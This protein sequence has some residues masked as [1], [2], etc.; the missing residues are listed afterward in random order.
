MIKDQT[1]KNKR[2]SSLSKK[3]K[4]SIVMKKMKVLQFTQLPNEAHF[5]FFKKVT[6]DYPNAAQDVKDEIHRAYRPLLTW[7]EYE[8]A[9]IEWYRKSVLTAAIADANQRLDHAVVGLTAQV[10]GA[11]YNVDPGVAKAAEEVFTMLHSHGRVIKKPYLQEVGAVEAILLHLDTD[12]KA[13]SKT[14]EVDHWTEEIRSALEEFVQLYEDREAKTLLKPDPGF[15]EVRHHIEE[16]W[17]EL[18]VIVNAGVQVTIAHKDFEAYIDMFNPEIDALNAEFH[19]VRYDIAEAEPAPI[20]RQSFTGQACT[21]MPE[22]LYVS[23]K[24]TVKL[25]LGKDF[26]VTY[27]DN[28]EVG[29]AQ[30]TIHGKGKYRGHKTVTFIISR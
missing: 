29:N 2:I 10:N 4:F 24:G 5:K 18:V 7:F 16:Y 15:P 25:E 30:C 28:V 11:R 21:P 17:R 23:P 27:K 13:D 26:N 19:R 3:I 1:I 6:D 22:V 12:L 14:A 8:T 20:E 9:C